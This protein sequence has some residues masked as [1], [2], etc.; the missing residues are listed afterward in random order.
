MAETKKK[1][2]AAGAGAAKG[3]D[4]RLA[5]KV[6]LIT[7]AA[8][9]LGGEIT[10]AYAREGATVIMTGRTKDRIEAAREA[11]IKDT[12]VAADKIDTAILDGGDPDSIRA[13]MDAIKKKH[14]R[15]SI[16]VNN[17]GSAGPKQLLENVPLTEEE[18][19]ASGDTETV[20]DAMRNIFG[21]T[22]NLSR[23]AAPLIPPGGSVINISTIFSHTRYYGRTAYVVPKAA[24]NAL[25]RRLAEELGP[26][27][28]RVNTVFP[29]PIESDRIRTVFAAMDELQGDEEGATADHFTGRMSLSRSISGTEPKKTLP[30]PVDIAG[31]CTFLASEESA[32]MNGNEI[33]VTH[34]MRARKD[35]RSTYL[36]R[37]SM[38]S[39]DGAGLTVLIVAGEDWE[40][41]LEMAR[42]QIACGAKVLLGL[43]RAAD[44]A[45]A[46][47]RV[48]AHP[49]GDGLTIVRLRRSEAT[50]MEE[51]L[52]G[53]S[54]EHGP[55]TSAIVLPLKPAGYYA[56]PLL[57]ADDEMVEN[58]MDQELVGAIALGRTLSRYWKLHPDLLQDP[59]FVF[60]T[61]KS[62]G[63]GD[64]YSEIYGAGI[65]QLITIWRDESRVEREQKRIERAAWGNLIVRHTNAEEENLRFAG[66]HATRIVFKEQKIAETKL[67]LPGN[68]GEEAGASSAMVGFAE[69]I[70]GLHLGKVAFITGG[71]AGIGGQV[72][73]LLALAGAKVMMVARSED[74]LVAARDRIVGE[75]QDVGFSGVD[76]RVKYIANV[77][78]SDFE[79]LRAAFDETMEI[80][81]R[82]D[83]LINNAG[84]AGAED[85]VVDMALDDWR[86]TLDANLVSNYLLMHHAVPFMRAQRS[87]YILNV[88]SYFGGEKF[89]AVAYPNRADYAVSKAG[90]RAMVE[91]FSRFLGPEIQCN[92]IAPGPVAGDRLAG[93]GGR[94]GLFKRRARLILEN[95][96][97]NAI[98]AAVIRAVREGAEV[99]HVLGRLKRNDIAYLSHDKETPEAL[100]KLVLDCA[101]DGDGTCTW[102]RFLMTQ[103][104]AARLLKRIAMGGYL[105]DLS[106][107]SGRAEKGEDWLAVVP[108]EEVPFLPQ[109]R[110]EEDAE[111]IGKGVTSQLHLGAMPTEAD[112]AQATVFYLADR[113][114]SGETFMPSGGLAVERSTVEREMFGSPK[115]ERLE[116]MKGKTVWIVCQHLADYIAAT[117]RH[118]IGDLG[119]AKVVLLTQSKT[120]GQA[121][122]NKLGDCPADNVHTIVAGE[123]IE[124]AMDEALQKWG[125]PTTVVSMPY[126]G[127][128]DR[129]FESDAPLSPEEFRHVVEQNL[130]HHFRVSRKASLYDGCQLVLV[131]P[132]VPFGKK[133]PAFAL[134]NFIKT[135]LHA[136]T[137]TLAVE[138]ERLVHDVAANQIN[139]TRRVRSE[140]PRNE[141]EHQEELSRFARA[142]LLVGAPLPDAEDSRY[143]S[144]IY[145]GTSMTV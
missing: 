105:L 36:N 31:A 41:A 106:E 40:D 125:R 18:M 13:A 122:V 103:E 38:R 134:A 112:V 87:G 133:G 8:G 101:R 143:R 58:F 20:A 137:A 83:Y 107:W 68:I 19:D 100:R 139:L 118:L 131:S 110:I 23:I 93:T 121:I 55:I 28:V 96:R 54:A 50:G 7:G 77:D 130:T 12:G 111:K 63:K 89:L 102:D 45:Q 73:R 138:N 135:T 85:M 15:I 69:N 53:Y 82:V 127:L 84:V 1:T 115:A 66:G 26:N 56:D 9:N 116:A 64:I 80:F 126:E 35:S 104:L 46:T 37:P 32:G 39:L 117:V 95:K 142:V 141:E 99:D 114:V 72:A 108:P 97:L 124:P 11:V 123:D 75:L 29:G 33:D 51:V 44:V 145:R 140:E 81:G 6:A 42:I 128:P 22:W 4:G 10:R 74:Q 60:M 79:S 65:A 86:F 25:S 57:E 91:S 14:S 88:S 144:R 5:G 136:F 98:Y 2:A 109:Q 48:M 27:G 67:Y 92:A 71:S 129:L 24:L 52:A 30:L 120:G 16:L 59:R 61:N 21:V 43:P 62:D 78:V 119:V 94:P 49:A 113:A 76:R 132:D 3:V 90:Q 34:G 17:A 70:T 47:A